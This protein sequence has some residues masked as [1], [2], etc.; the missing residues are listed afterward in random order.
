MFLVELLKYNCTAYNFLDVLQLFLQ[1]CKFSVQLFQNTLIKA[2]VT[3]F[4]RVLGYCSPLF[5]LRIWKR[6]KKLPMRIYNTHHIYF[7]NPKLHL[8]SWYQP[9]WGMPWSPSSCLCI[10]GVIY[11]YIIYIY[12]I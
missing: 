10:L 3:I 2:F 4:S 5:F 6:S 9:W 8:P 11:V 7:Q 1:F 12:S